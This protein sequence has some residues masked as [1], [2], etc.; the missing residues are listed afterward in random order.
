MA[1]SAGKYY[2]D[3]AIGNC[4]IA[5]T[6]AAGV[7]IPIST[8]TAATVGLWNTSTTKNAVLM[9]ATLGVTSGTIALGVFGIAVIN[10]GFNIATGAPV[11]AVTAVTP[12][13]ALLGSGKSSAMTS[14]S[15]TATTTGGTAPVWFGKSIESAT[16]GL[17]VFDGIYQ[18]DGSVIVTPGQLV[19]LCSSV[20][21]TAIMTCSLAWAEVD[22]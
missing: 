17:G 5:S 14:F 20:A 2:T 18:F 15:A 10:G 12:K 22:V 6:T 11:S 21:Q 9:Y 8:G 19:Y 7:A 4:F 3:V 1:K 16:A 13:N